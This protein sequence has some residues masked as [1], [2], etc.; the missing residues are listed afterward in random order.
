[1]KRMLKV[2][3]ALAVIG[4]AAGAAWWGY[5]QVFGSGDVWYAQVDGERLS[6]AGENN[7]GFDYHYDLPAANAAGKTETLGFDTSRELRDG[8]YLQLKTLALRGV[9]SWEEVAWNKIPAAAQERLDPPADKPAAGD[10]LSDTPAAT[11]PG[12]EADAA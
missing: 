8:A 3:I 7:N 5:G 6:A 10:A 4:V 11:G 12:G 9:V 1:M 2:L